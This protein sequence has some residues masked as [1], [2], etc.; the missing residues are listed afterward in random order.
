MGEE[1]IK[2]PLTQDQTKALAHGPN[3]AIVPKSPPVGEYTVAI[4]NACNQV[5]QGKVEELRGKIKSVLKKIQTPKY[6]ITKREKG[7][8]GIEKRQDQ[9]HLDHRQGFLYGGHG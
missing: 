3:F 4:E 7:D 2:C 8:R 6:N 5:E 9:D 1:F